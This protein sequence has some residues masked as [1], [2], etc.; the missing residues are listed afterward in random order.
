MAE[1]ISGSEESLCEVGVVP[2]QDALFLCCVCGKVLATKWGIGRHEVGHANAHKLQCMLCQMLFST[3]CHY[4]G[5][6][7]VHHNS[8]P[9]MCGKCSKRYSYRIA[10]LRHAGMCRAKRRSAT[11]V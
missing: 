7:N 2:E 5:H 10:L 9:H 3:R 11:R 1:H 4:E 8:K 6:I